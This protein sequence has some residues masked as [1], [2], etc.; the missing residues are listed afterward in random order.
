MLLGIWL[1]GAVIG[2]LNSNAVIDYFESLLPPEA[3]LIVIS[4]PE[5]FVS[6]LK[7]AIIIGLILTLPFI[8][9][10]VIDL[11][12][13]KFPRL[14]IKNPY[15]ITAFCYVLFIIGASFAF[16]FI[17]PLAMKFLLSYGG[18]KVQ[19]WMTLSK[20]T[21]FATLLTVVFGFAFELPVF[22]I[23]LSYVGVLKSDKMIKNRK[24]IVLGMFIAAAM[25]TPPDPLS[26]VM[27][28][29]PL[30][31]LFEIGVY[32]ARVRERSI[33]KKTDVVLTKTGK[34]II[35][36]GHAAASEAKQREALAEIGLT[37]E[38]LERFSRQMQRDLGQIPNEE[39]NESSGENQPSEEPGDN[40]DENQ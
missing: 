31:I 9:Y 39:F 5:A 28:A 30:L 1:A 20:Y 2:Y 18:P 12:K 29:I 14:G 36:E 7:I 37:M 13:T 40:T 15:T 22:M 23:V 33:A 25:V 32:F 27:L 17:L 35:P 21:S 3:K 38:D 26:L 10:T 4:P 8:M 11:L 34:L 16:F 19:D 6:Q 24:Y